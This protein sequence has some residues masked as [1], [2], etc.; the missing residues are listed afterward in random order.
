VIIEDENVDERTKA[1]LEAFN[2]DAPLHTH[3]WAIY[4]RYLRYAD[5]SGKK[6][7]VIAFF[8][9]DALSIPVVLLG[10]GLLEV[11]EKGLFLVDRVRMRNWTPEERLRHLLSKIT[12]IDI[13]MDRDFYDAKEI[14]ERKARKRREAAQES[15]TAS[16]L[17][18]G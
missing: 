8:P 17:N 14:M 5:T 6:A 11:W 16:S 7:A 2:L 18:D 9:I 10:L 4:A 13:P 12:P 15:S 1:E 3:I